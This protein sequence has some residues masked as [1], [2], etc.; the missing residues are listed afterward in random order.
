MVLL[1]NHGGQGKEKDGEARKGR[2]AGH[3]LFTGL[4][5]EKRAT[6]K[7]LARKSGRN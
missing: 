7:E 3:E 6:K 4:D 1:P 5:E 2:A